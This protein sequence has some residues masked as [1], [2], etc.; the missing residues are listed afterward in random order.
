MAKKIN[1]V[2][3]L[4]R[5]LGRTHKAVGRWLR[6]DRW[7]FSRRGP[8]SAADVPAMKAWAAQ[9]LAP[10][11]A[12]GVSDL[13]PAVGLSAKSKVD[14]ALK[15]ERIEMSKLIRQLKAGKLHPIE[16]C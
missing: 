12:S 7:P 5:H 1:S 16:D 13:S 14:I 10:A 11:P 4:A 3:E 2:R 8:W 6:D 15:L 9:E